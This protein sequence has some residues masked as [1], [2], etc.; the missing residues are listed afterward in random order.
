MGRWRG[1]PRPPIAALPSKEHRALARA[2]FLRLIDPGAT[3]QD[4]TRRR[5]AMAEFALPDPQQTARLQEVADAFIAARLLVV[6]RAPAGRRSTET[7]LEVSHEALIREW[8]RLGDWLR[9]TREDIRRQQA[10]SADAAEWERRERAADHLYRGS[11]LLEAEAWAARQYAE[12]TGELEFLDAARLERDR[13]TLEERDR[14]TRQLALMRQAATR[15][16]ALVAILALFLVVAAALS[17]L[18][19]QQRLAGAPG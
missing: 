19:S 1:M 10:I 3:E 7:T 16:R 17:V 11:L 13:Q 14:Q 18:R 5:A 12:R 9:E 2:L 6:T 15:L 8:E 4:T